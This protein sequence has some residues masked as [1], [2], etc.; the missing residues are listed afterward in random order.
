M[1]GDETVTRVRAI[2][3]EQDQLRKRLAMLDS[4]LREILQL[5]MGTRKPPRTTLSDKD[6]AALV[7]AVVRRNHERLS[8]V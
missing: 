7:A 1:Q 5:D 6:S 2:V 8:T 4:E 3:Q